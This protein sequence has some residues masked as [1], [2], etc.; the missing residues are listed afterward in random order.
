MFQGMHYVY[1]VYKERSFSK[2]AN[3]LYI[4]Q[5]SLSATIKKIESRIGAP[6]FDRSTTPVQL[7]ECGQEYIRCVEK[8]LDVQNDFENYIGNMNELKTGQISIG[9]SNLFASFILPPYISAFKQRYPQ[10]K[11]N[12]IEANTALLDER[13]AA[14]TLDMIIDNHAIN[15]ELYTGYALCPDHLLL[16]VPGPL[17]PQNLDP[18]ARLTAFDILRDRHLDDAFPTVSLHLF[19]DV[20]FI[21]LRSGNDTRKRAEQI[22]QHHHFTPN[23]LLKLDQQA[24]AYHVSCYGMGV[25]FVSDALIKKVRPDPDMI[26]CRLDGEEASRTISFYHKKGKY[27]TKAMQEFLNIALA[28]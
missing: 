21:F 27:V 24:T 28:T 25:T 3:N 4:S 2:A 20:P 1:E 17:I 9:A 26:F 10:V 6:I 13:L 16:A 8:I 19:Q 12:L 22:C 7:T 14:G 5:P 23:V 15:P 11:V 18:A